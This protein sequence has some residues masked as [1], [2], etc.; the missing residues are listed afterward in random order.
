M[1]QLFSPLLQNG[2]RFFCGS[3]CRHQ[4]NS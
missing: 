2:Q 1:H 4:V 3:L